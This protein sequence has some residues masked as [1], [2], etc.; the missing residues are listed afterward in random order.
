MDLQQKPHIVSKSKSFKEN[1]TKIPP[2]F[3]FNFNLNNV[4]VARKIYKN[5]QFHSR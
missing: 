5:E 2:Y 3:F 1:L 4:S